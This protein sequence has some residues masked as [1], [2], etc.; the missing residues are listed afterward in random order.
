MISGSCGRFRAKYRQSRSYLL[1]LFKRLPRSKVKSIESK[2]L[3][4]NGANNCRI[5]IDKYERNTVLTI[6][7]TERSDSGKYKLVLKNSSGKKETAADGVVLG[8][9]SRPEGPI[10][11]TDVRAKKATVKWK[12]P[13]DDGGCPISH[14]QLEK[15]DLVMAT[16]F[17]MGCLSSGSQCLDLFLL[18]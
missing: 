18:E 16:S 10:E 15:M 6:R 3:A 9:P 8:K 11:V 2:P 5:T 4:K 1:D 13:V 17:R 14:Y 7:K 12:K